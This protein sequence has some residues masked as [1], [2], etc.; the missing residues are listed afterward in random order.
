MA[1]GATKQ[2]ALLED[3]PLRLDVRQR[4]LDLPVYSPRPDERGVERLDLIGG[5]DDL[6]ISS[7][8]ETIEL[9][10]QLQ[11]GTLDFSLAARC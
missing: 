1:R 3:M 6:D 10:E 7:S 8:V 4:K 9:I 5:H 11:H 2:D